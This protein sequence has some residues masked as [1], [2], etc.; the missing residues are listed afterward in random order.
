MH[1]KLH[2]SNVNKDLQIIPSLGSL[3]SNKDISEGVSFPTFYDVHEEGKTLIG[4]D[5]IEWKRGDSP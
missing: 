5:L 4:H 2:K 1:Q 3:R